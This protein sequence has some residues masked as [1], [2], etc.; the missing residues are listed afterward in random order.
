MLFSVDFCAS[1]GSL[2]RIIPYWE[3]FHAVCLDNANNGSH[4]MEIDRR[5]LVRLFSVSGTFEW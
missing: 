1:F 2:G 5:T 3:Y 4:A